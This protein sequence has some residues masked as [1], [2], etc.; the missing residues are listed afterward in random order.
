MAGRLVATV[1]I[2]AVTYLMIIG[3]ARTNVTAILALGLNAL[4]IARLATQILDLGVPTKSSGEVRKRVHQ[5]VRSWQCALKAR[6]ISGGGFH[7][8]NCR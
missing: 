2:I 4:N 8:D 7:P 6:I 1:V 5:N 3:P